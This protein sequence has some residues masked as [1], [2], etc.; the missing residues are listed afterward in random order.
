MIYIILFYLMICTALSAFEASS[1]TPDD[2]S[3][4][5]GPLRVN[6]ANPRYFTNDSGRAIYLTGSHT[7]NNFKDIGA[8]GPLSNYDYDGYLDFLQQYN[9]NFIRL[10][11]SELTYKGEP[12]KYTRPYPW[13]R[14]GPGTAL[15]G[16]P[17][18]DLTRHNREYFDRLRSRVI[19][20]RDRGIYVSIM[21]FEGWGLYFSEPPWR[22]D[23]HPFNIKNN[24]NGI[25]GDPDRDGMGLESHTLQISAIVRI[26]EDYVKKVID[27]VND[28][29]N[30]L[31]EISN[32]DHQGSVEWQY[33]FINFIKDY[34]KTKQ[35]QHPVGMTTH[36]KLQNK[37]VF[38][39]NADWV[40]PSVKSWPGE[41]DPYKVDPPVT[42]GKKVVILDTDH[43]WGIGGDRK[44][45]WKA[46]TRGYNPIYM[47]IPN[48]S[49][50]TASEK[51]WD[52]NDAR[53]AMGYTLTYATKMNLKDMLPLNDLSSTSYCLANLGS[54]Y[55]VYQPKSN[56]TFTVK[57]Q[58]GKYN[59]EWFN[60][61]KGTIASSGK[62]TVSSG[63]ISFTPPFLG[64]AVLYIFSDK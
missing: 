42:D 43:L 34:E 48:Q 46:F 10:W 47:D 7:W 33:H 9:H 62:L 29:D 17:K 59:Y 57:L 3:L 55:L 31:F 45:V 36:V 18:F 1:D 58:A 40:A 52:L 41:L 38:N 11:T 12:V 63:N 16:K 56:K 22:W 14:T 25:D 54:E 37:V 8:T 4:K 35:K 27:T 60:P 6:P 20:A 50:F 26:Q 39:S 44:W 13:P 64:D 15:D 51:T 32:E 61:E 21:L 23:G 2:I 49:T 28:L 24:I 5:G 30:V 19:S 53:R